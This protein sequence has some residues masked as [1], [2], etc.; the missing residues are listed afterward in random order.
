MQ[1]GFGPAGARPHATPP[2]ILDRGLGAGLIARRKRSQPT[3]TTYG[4]AGAADRRRAS[5]REAQVP[6]GPGRPAG[7]RAGARGHA[8]VRP[9]M[10]HN[11]PAMGYCL[12]PLPASAGV[13]IPVDRIERARGRRDDD[14]PI[15]RHWLHAAG[16]PENSIRR[17]DRLLCSRPAS[18]RPLMPSCAAPGLSAFVPSRRRRQTRDPRIRCSLQQQQLTWYGSNGTEHWHPQ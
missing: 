18:A 4:R 3:T 13:S 5:A 8:H 17:V 7:G 9:S 1:L 11:L 15:R 12:L 2:R 14:V 6:R 10:D 16:S